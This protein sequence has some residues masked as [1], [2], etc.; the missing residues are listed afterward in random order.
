[1]H[2]WWCW[3]DLGWVPV[4][5]PSTSVTPQGVG[6]GE[7]GGK[8]LRGQGRGGLIKQK[9]YAQ[10]QEETE[11]FILYFPFREAGLQYV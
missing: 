4:A 3:V 9:S 11:G 10:K 7:K 1:M 6:Q 2:T 8:S 5:P